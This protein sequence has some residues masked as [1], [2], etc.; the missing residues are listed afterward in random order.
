MKSFQEFVENL[1]MQGK[2]FLIYSY[3]YMLI[4]TGFS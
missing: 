2:R 4:I 3:L 1:W